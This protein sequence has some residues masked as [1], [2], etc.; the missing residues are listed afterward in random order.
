MLLRSNGEMEQGG[1]AVFAGHC[2]SRQRPRALSRW[3]LVSAH[4]A[5]VLANDPPV[6]NN[7][8][9]NKRGAHDMTV[10]LMATWQLCRLRMDNLMISNCVYWATPPCALPTRLYSTVQ[11]LLYIAKKRILAKAGCRIKNRNRHRLKCVQ[12]KLTKPTPDIDEHWHLEQA[13]MIY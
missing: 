9:I 10:V 12:D 6:T 5:G 13:I 4:L 2:G 1:L 8:I 3:L 7:S 11:L